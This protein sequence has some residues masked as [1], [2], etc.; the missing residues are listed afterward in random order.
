MDQHQLEHHFGIDNIPFGIASSSRHPQPAAVTRFENKIVFLAELDDA[1]HSTGIPR[2]VFTQ[3]T[4]NEFASL[5]RAA[6]TAVRKAIQSAITSDALPAAAV[7]DVAETTAHLPVATGDFTDF[8]CSPHHNRRAGSALLGMSPNLP[9]A[10]LHQPL[11][12]AGR[13]SSLAIS[14]TAVV[15]QVGQ[16]FEHGS[17]GLK[18]TRKQVTCAPARWMDYELEMGVVVGKPVPRGHFVTAAKALEHVFGYILLNDWSARCIQQF[19]MI[20]IG[21]LNSKH[22]ATTLGAWIV[23]PDALEPFRTALSTQKDH[24]QLAP[25]L[26]DPAGTIPDVSLQVSRAKNAGQ[27][28]EVVC[29]TNVKVMDWTFE[30]ILAHQSIS[31]PG[32]RSG[33]LMGIGTVSGPD[34]S[35]YGCVMEEFAPGHTPNRDYVQDNEVV[36]LLGYCGAGVGFGDC[37]AQ[38]L[39][40][41]ESSVWQSP[42]AK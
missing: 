6:H 41:R 8:S 36:Q 11:G 7:E 13:T 4:L 34:E 18:G 26:S 14:G 17:E 29:K 24:S 32:L 23:T 2:E 1:L 3:P 16:Y 21:P 35:Q 27:P 30:Q 42:E 9:P 20:P 12:Y 28:F 39:P 19:E 37:T 31:G 15:R 38:L 5:G 40:A 22:A 25:Y 10:Y 33:D